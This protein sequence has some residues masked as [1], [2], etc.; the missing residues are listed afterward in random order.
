M[1]GVLLFLVNGLKAIAALNK[2]SR[3]PFN[4]ITFVMK[5]NSG[6]L[7]LFEIQLVIPDKRHH[8]PSLDG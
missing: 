1:A 5:S 6:I 4:E 3:V 7:Y 8:V 2:P